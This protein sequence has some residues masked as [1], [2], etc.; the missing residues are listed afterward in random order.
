MNGA[1]KAYAP[2]IVRDEGVAAAT[3]TAPANELTPNTVAVSARVRNPR[4]GPTARTLVVSNI[5]I[6]EESWTLL[7]T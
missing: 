3:Y 5:T 4:R 6:A 7:V 1:F 2:F